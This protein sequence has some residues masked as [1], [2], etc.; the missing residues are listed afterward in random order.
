MAGTSR[1]VRR[2]LPAWVVM[3]VRRGL[4]RLDPYVNLSYSQEG[5]DMILRRL[6]ERQQRGFYVDVGAHDPYRFSNTCY[7]HRRGWRG[8]NIDPNPLAIKAFDRERAADVNVCVGVA[9]VPGK[10]MFHLF[11]DP[12]LNTFDADLARERVKLPFYRLLETRDVPVRRLDDLL[13]QYLP[14]G[15]KIDFLSVDVEGMDLAVL[16]SN[17]WTQFR[18]HLLLVEAHQRFASGVEGDPVNSFATEIGYQLIAKTLN[19]LIYEDIRDSRD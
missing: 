11:N 17:D 19:T 2:S 8:I 13:R 14:Q 3:I 4:E 18:P 16:R 12:A 7:F 6:L 5:E 15:Q 9:D 1:G 10:L